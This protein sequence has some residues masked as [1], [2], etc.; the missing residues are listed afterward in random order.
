MIEKVVKDVSNT[1]NTTP[2]LDF[3]NLVGVEAH[4]K[5]LSS[6]LCLN[7]VDEVRMVGIWGAAGIGKTTIARALYNQISDNFQLGFFMDN[8]KESYKGVK[9]IDDYGLK[10]RL[11]ELFLSKTVDHQDIKIQHLGAIKERL[12]NKRVLIVLDDV[13]EVEQ[14]VALANQPNWFGLGSRI[15][16]TTEDRQL[17]KTHGINHVYKV[18][19]PSCDEAIQIFSRYAFG[20]S[21][22]PRNFMELAIETTKLV[23][24][25]PLGL[26]VL[27]S[28]LRG[29]GREEWL[30]ALPRLRSSLDAKL[31]KILEVGYNCLH[32]KDKAI[33]LHI[34]CFFNGEKV[35]RI[36]QL[37][38]TSDLDIAFGL[39]VLADKSLI[40]ISTDR[41]VMMHYLLKKLGRAVVRK[42]SIYEPGK[43]QFL[44]N[45]EEIC[46][47][48]QDETVRICIFIFFIFTFAC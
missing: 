48:L 47:V 6:L 20:N 10:L 26:S 11:Q 45:S 24:N 3:N 2:S 14:L 29:K 1:L 25:L 19:F 44:V 32:E 38:A 41:R 8:I 46:D 27:G 22:P 28:S 7:C 9:G 23:G 39:K 40:H 34:A 42:Q 16:L 37:L 21:F 15:I 33:F 4:V 30:L 13:D 5:R 43:R 36:I 17:L 18:D 35:D 12:K 31:E